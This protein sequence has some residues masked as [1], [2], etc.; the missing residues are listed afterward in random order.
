MIKKQFND[1]ERA[2][3]LYTNTPLL[4][5]LFTV[6]LPGLLSTLMIGVY[7]F[8]TQIII[9]RLLP[10]TI[11]F[12]TTFGHTE[13]EIKYLIGIKGGQFVSIGDIVKGSMS[14]SSPIL[15]VV[16]TS[17]FFLATGAGVL[18]T[19]SLGKNNKVKA[20]E[21]FKTSF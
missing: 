9:V 21:V 5:A 11:D 18:F 14:I 13:D 2:H 8:A 16:G 4:K 12:Q 1:N 19:Q 6:I 7:I 3:R 15:T 17:P 20:N 10:L